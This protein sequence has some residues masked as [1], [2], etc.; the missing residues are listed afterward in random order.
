MP[1]G[2]WCYEIMEG[3]RVTVQRLREVL[4]QLGL[5][6]KGNKPELLKRLSEH[7]P[8][9]TWKQLI[10]KEGTS[11]EEDEVE[12]PTEGNEESEAEEE[13]RRLIPRSLSRHEICEDSRLRDRELEIL[14]RERDIMQ[15][16]LEILRREREANASARIMASPMTT[17]SQ[18]TTRLQPKALSELL[19]EFSG[20]ENTF[21]IWRKQ[22]ELIKT[23]YQLDDGTARILIGMRLRQKALQWFHSRPEHLELSVDDL[24]E[25]M[26]TMFDHRPTK[27]DLRKQFEKRNWRN[28]ETFSDYF[29]DKIVLANK[30]PVDEDEL[31]DYV[32]DGIPDET[33]RNQARIQRFKEKEELLKAFEKI[34]IRTANRNFA[35]DSNNTVANKV[36]S[37]RK[38]R[39]PFQGVAG[40]TNAETKCYN[41]NRTG[42]I[43]RNCDKPKRERGSCFECGESDHQL[44]DCPRRKEATAGPRT[45]KRTDQRQ[46]EAAAQVSNIVERTR[47]AN[48]FLKTV[49]LQLSTNGLSYNRKCE[50]QIDTASPISL[51]KL[52]FVPSNLISEITEG[53]YEG[54][55]GSTLEILGRVEAKVLVE[56]LG[57]SSVT[58]R[59]VPDHAMKCDTILG[60]DAIETFGLT[61]AKREEKHEEEIAE[62]L[63]I[64]SSVSVSD[65]LEKLDVNPEISSEMRDR[66]MEK[67]CTGYLRAEKPSEP[68]LRAEIKLH[69]KEKQPFY[70]TPGRLSYEEKNRLREILDDL[71]ARRIIRPGSSEYASRTVLVK[72][73][74]GKTRLCIDYRT[75]NKITARDNYPLPVIEDQINALQGK[76]YFSLLDLKDGFHHV[77]VAEDSVKYTAF[78]TPF[79]QYEYLKMPFGLKN[80]PARFQRYVNEVLSDLIKV[81]TVIVYMD[82][83]LIAT[84]TLEEHFEVLEQA[85]RLLTQNRLELRMDK[86]RFLYKEIEFLGY[87]VSRRGVRPN[88]SGINAVKNFPTPKNVRDVQSFLGLSSYFRKFIENFATISSPLYSLFKKGAVFEFGQQQMNAFETLKK[89]LIEAPILS[90]YNPEDPTE[91]HCDASSQGFGAVLLQRKADNRFHPIFY[92]SKKTTEVEARYH[93]YELETLA[94]IYALKR[95]RIYL[96]GVPFKIVTD[97]NALVMTLNKQIVNPR[98]ARWALELQNY[99]YRTEHRPGKRMSHV[100]A[101]SRTNSILV[102]EDNSFEFNLSV[103]QTQDV[104]VKELKSRLEKKQDEFYEMRNGLI[105]RKKK[106]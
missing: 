62:I 27:V 69:I 96:Q 45:S 33:M 13:Q 19:S 85:F 4:K 51:V 15:R 39:L 12:Q 8:G 75:L 3:D 74:N 59:V 61:L 30:I 21:H 38:T 84:D 2:E 7:D 22:F 102:I 65:E 68:K 47:S 72:K 36:E 44:R 83:F 73:K 10:P 88:D 5:S 76:Q 28:D 52:R 53:R 97:C 31:T 101:L 71:L 92:F 41:C 105:Y 95:F 64:D 50:T 80:A 66:F 11:M 55:N 23:T 82:D 37:K 35:R 1:V 20:S 100:D 25:R 67:L 99:D 26:Q 32:I 94:I 40:Q 6:S 9:G 103:C 70:F 29:H 42:H 17:A 24:I 78:V 63:N 48:E 106:K 89:K 91:L 60:R 90:I 57:A 18:G 43:A 49:E 77:N 93:S 34:T 58:F 46:A 79:G 86:C 16:E 14:R 104:K 87:V 56:D 54:I 98:I 81:G